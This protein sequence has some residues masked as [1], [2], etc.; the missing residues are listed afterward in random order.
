MT[1]RTSKI[2]SITI[3][4]DVGDKHIQA[5]ILEGDHMQRASL[6]TTATGLRR[7]L[8][9]FSQPTTVVI[10][11][12]TH[13]PWISRFIQDAGHR[14][15]VANPRN[16]RLIAEGHR[17]NDRVDAE[18]LARI[19]R[20]DP[21]LLSPIQH[22]GADAHADLLLIRARDSLVRAR[23]KLINTIRG[24]TKSFGVTLPRCSAST[25]PAKVLD[26]VPEQLQPVLTALCELVVEHT[27]RIRRYDAKIASLPDDY[28]ELTLLTQVPGVGPI[29][30]AAFLLT[31]ED[32]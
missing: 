31:I 12:G 30:S 19:G 6:S 24:I 26:I 21:K 5:C 14:V 9:P 3:G 28:P 4:M 15:I 2:A 32:P 11:V 25:L 18:L 8:A 23:T 20:L 29:T 27:K 13:S 1:K 16:V 7:F 22:R 10:E 17:K